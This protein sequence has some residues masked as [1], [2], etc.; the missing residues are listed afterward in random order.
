MSSLLVE[1][2]DFLVLADKE[3]TVLSDAWILAK[4]GFIDSFGTGPSPVVEQSVTKL[5]GRG[6]ILTP[7]FVNTHHHLYQ[8]MARAYTPGNNLPLLPWLA[9]MNKLWKAF[10]E[11]DLHACTRLGLAELMMSGA[12][13][14]AD[15]HYVFP[16]GAKDMTLAQFD[17]ASLMGVRFQASRGSMNVKSDLIS[18]WALQ[19]EDAILADTESLIQSEHDSSH[20]SFRQIIVAPCAATSCSASLLEKSAELAKKYKVGL[21]THCGETVAENDFSI[22]KFG[23]RPLA[24]L[25]DRGWDYDRVWLA[26]GIHFEDSELSQMAE[27]GIGVAHC[28]NAN[29]RLGSGICRV[30]ELIEKGI[31]V[32]V[33]VDG[34]ASNDSGHML[35]EL[36][37]AMYLARVKYGAEAMSAL[38]TIDLGTWRAAELMGR[39]DIGKI[40]SGMCADFALFPAEDLYS[41]GAENPVDALLICH[42]REVTDLVVGGEIRIRDHEFVDLDLAALRQ[43]HHQRADRVREKA[44]I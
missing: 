4:E 13:T 36:R 26:H 22:E 1:N 31:K 21:H 32:G 15:H 39:R 23:M 33:G 2:I 37:Q 5:S 29:M 10:R 11:D 19:D 27:Y 14:I 41:N 30:P 28:P 17:A 7:G 18:S 35:A 16:E 8:N 44:F 9:H 3:Q 40:E 6:K 25:L 38:D 42:A 24:Y 43:E 34:S 20:G 12:T